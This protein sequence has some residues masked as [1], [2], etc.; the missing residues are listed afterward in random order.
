[1]KLKVKPRK[2]ALRTGLFLVCLAVSTTCLALGF[3]NAGKWAALPAVFLSAGLWLFARNS[4]TGWLPLASLALS[5][6]LAALGTL[7]G[8][9]PVLA[10]PGAAF[11]LATWD[12]ALLEHS[13]KGCPEAEDTRRYEIK[14]IR[15]LAFSLTLGLLAAELGLGLQFRIPFGL[16]LLLAAL[17]LYSLDRMTRSFKG[18]NPG[19]E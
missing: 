1:M 11:A 15:S 8:A 12:L 17:A 13:L 5:A 2:I 14:H 10:I 18:R 9:Q 6:G 16:M 4:P 19:G 3:W 7:L